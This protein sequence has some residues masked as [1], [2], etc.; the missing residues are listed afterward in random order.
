MKENAESSDRVG[1]EVGIDVVGVVIVSEGVMVGTDAIP[2]VPLK[3]SVL[4]TE[5]EFVLIV[6]EPGVEV[7]VG[8]SSV[9]VGVSVGA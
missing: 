2:L 9:S 4:E 1:T 7:L 3:T 8:G 6:P 5:L